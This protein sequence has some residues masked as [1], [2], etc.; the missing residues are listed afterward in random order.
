MNQKIDEKEHS[1]EMHI[2]FIKKVFGDHP[3]KM[4]P[5]MVG[6]LSAKSEQAYGKKLAPYLQDDQ[7]LFIISSDF[8]H[9]GAN[10]DYY[11]YDK[12]EG[13]IW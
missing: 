3:M 10:F 4:V 5:I 1:L 12:A 7:T 8:C 6:N 2:P 11:P 13:E 9:W